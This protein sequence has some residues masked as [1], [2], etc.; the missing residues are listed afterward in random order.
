M[1]IDLPSTSLATFLY[2]I[3][4]EIYNGYYIDKGTT[5]LDLYLDN[6]NFSF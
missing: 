4:M 1:Y 3:E 2:R 5:Y 6:N